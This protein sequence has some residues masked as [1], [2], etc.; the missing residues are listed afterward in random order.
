MNAISTWTLLLTSV[1]VF[2]AV[3]G[4]Q[5]LLRA[6]NAGDS[7]PQMLAIGSGGHLFVVSSFP[8]V[9]GQPSTRVVELDAQGTRLGSIEVPQMAIPAT[10]VTDAQG[11]LILGG[12]D[13][14]YQGIVLKLDRQLRNVVFTRSLPAN[15]RA[16]AVDPSGNIYLTGSTSSEAFPV[17]AGAFQTRP[18]GGDRF[19]RAAY[20]F[21]TK[22]SPGGDQVLYST[23]FGDDATYCFGGSACIGA[24]GSTTGTG[25]GLDSSG[26]V[27]IAGVTNAYGLPATPGA[28]AETCSCQYRS[29]AGFIA[30]FQP[31]A[32]QQLQWSTFLS[33]KAAIPYTSVAV[34]SMAL[35][36]AGNVIVGGSAPGG[37]PIPAGT[38]QPGPP[39]GSQDTEGFVIQVN[40]AGTAVMWGTY[41]GGS[42]SS[43]VKAVRL[44]PQGRVVFTGVGVGPA[45]WTPSQP[46]LYVT[47]V[48]RLTSDGASLA[49]FY[50][51]PLGVTGQDLTI[52]S[53][54]TFAAIGELGTLWI[55]TAVPGPSLLAVTNS[56]SGLFGSL[57][58][59]E[60]IT[61]YG[62]GLGP[63]IP[64][65]G[66]VKNGAFTTALGGL[67]VLFDGVA[68]PLLYADSG[69]INAVVPRGIGTATHI[70]IVTPAGTVDGPTL[71]VVYTAVPGVFGD[72][73]TGLAAALNQDGSINSRLNPARRGSI[74]TVFA[75]GCGANYYA[76][77]AV[78]PLEIHDWTGPVWVLTD[79]RSL[80]VAFA[81]DAPGLVAGVMQI[82]FRV[83]DTLPGGDIDTLSF[84]L[85]VGG[86]MSAENRIAI[87][88]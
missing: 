41:F 59:T 84:W 64:V 36:A 26:G 47:Y 14:T 51:A 82:N 81:G 80:E 7:A 49:D 1:F 42:P 29:M 67:E 2:P 43:F 15:V 5:I 11:D 8:G 46:S 52:T 18:P 62:L 31:A 3:A 79:S 22:I 58:R 77:G 34:N 21:V 53:D 30:K 48:A 75:T 60:L 68:A 61:L 24:F 87:A 55:E 50:Q 23:F 33:G 73:R 83:P 63:Q 38:I 32:A 78:V 85:D 27:V 40:N 66:E 4:N 86:V 74:V 71:P 9:S 72:S 88:P 28:L 6:L 19:G 65:N 17:T 20:A 10:A 45:Q 54:G 70:S 16:A 44:D 12:M 39:P 37:L 35:D 25:I 69:Q 76:D 57:S 13:A 56:A